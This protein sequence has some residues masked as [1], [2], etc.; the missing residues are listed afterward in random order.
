MATVTV[1][2]YLT[3]LVTGIKFKDGI[4]AT[5]GDQFAA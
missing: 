4:E 2:D 5:E 3:R 1:F